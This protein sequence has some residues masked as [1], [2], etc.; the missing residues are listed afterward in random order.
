[1]TTT[2]PAIPPPVLVQQNGPVAPPAAS[3]PKPNGT[4]IYTIA[5]GANVWPDRLWPAKPSR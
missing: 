2:A 5:K 1:M 4:L 3:P